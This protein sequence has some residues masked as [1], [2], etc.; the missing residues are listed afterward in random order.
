VPAN[1]APRNFVDAVGH[2]RTGPVSDEEEW[3]PLVRV[4]VGQGSSTGC[5]GTGCGLPSPGEL[6]SCR[7]RAALLQRIEHRGDH[8]CP[9]KVVPGKTRQPRSLPRTQFKAGPAPAAPSIAPSRAPEAQSTTTARSPAASGG[10]V[11]LKGFSGVHRCRS[12]SFILPQQGFPFTHR[13]LA[14][15]GACRVAASTGSGSASCAELGRFQRT[16]SGDYELGVPQQPGGV[17][18]CYCSTA[19]SLTVRNR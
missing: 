1:R 18:S 19:G 2:A 15:A 9:H 16:G 11:A 10:A 3:S 4:T 8:S 12:R 17:G 6:S 5:G 7:E 14:L 13:V